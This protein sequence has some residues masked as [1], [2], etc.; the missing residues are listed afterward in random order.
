[1]AVSSSTRGRTSLGTCPRPANNARSHHQ[2]PVREFQQHPDGRASFST[3]DAPGSVRRDPRF[4]WCC[5]PAPRRSAWP[6][7]QSWIHRI[8]F[9]LIL[10]QFVLAFKEARFER[11]APASSCGGGCRREG[12]QEPPPRCVPTHPAA[13]T[14]SMPN[15]AASEPLQLLVGTRSGDRNGHHLFHQNE[16]V[17]SS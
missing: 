3:S 5:V 11:N 15:H 17:E 1:M 6:D 13:H 14:C 8:R 4:R 16:Q 12:D 10:I 2:P 7:Q 9:R